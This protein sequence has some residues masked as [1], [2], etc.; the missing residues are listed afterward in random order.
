MQLSLPR[1]ALALA[2]CLLLGACDFD[3]PA[4]AGPTRPIENRLVGDWVFQDKDAKSPEEMHVRKYDDF[5]YVVSIERD[6]YRAFHSDLGKLALLSVQDL[7]GSERK[8][9]FY[10]WQLSA[11]GSQLTLKRVATTVISD[12]LKDTVAIQDQLIANAAN[13]KL[14]GNDLVFTRKVAK[15]L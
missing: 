7:N 14:L 15:P 9:V 8:Y 6:I 11:D 13:P 10:A 1:A 4:S 2:A 5:G 3:A 12:Q